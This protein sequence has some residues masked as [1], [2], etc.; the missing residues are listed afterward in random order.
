MHIYAFGSVCRGDVLPDSDIDLLALVQ[1]QDPR[2]NPEDYSIYS[3]DRITQIWAE[4]NPFAWH[5]ALES[6]LLYSSDKFDFLASLGKPQPY[7]KARRDCEKFYALFRD[8]SVSIASHDESE[9][10]D[11]SMAFLAIRNF[12][13]CFSLGFLDK[14]DF[15]R[16]AAIQLGT[17]S[18]RLPKDVYRILERARILSTRAVGHI[19]TDD[20]RNI[21]VNQ[22]PRIEEWMAAILTGMHDHG[23]GARVQ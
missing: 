6:R 15:S 11:L 1:G 13:T 23:G 19:I 10:F 12:A 18:L 20:E 9:I 3:Y 8:A 21:A 4:G 7:G 22:F 5:L 17:Y 2:F 16:N 14:P